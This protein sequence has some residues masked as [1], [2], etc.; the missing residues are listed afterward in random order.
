MN[1]S[2][3][4]EAI[5]VAD[6]V[7]FHAQAD[8]KR[9]DRLKQL[10]KELPMACTDFF[11]SVAQTTSTLTRLVYAYDFR[12]FFQYLTLENPFFADVEPRFMTDQHLRMIKMRDIDGFQ[13]YLM[14]YY[15][16]D[17]ETGASKV[18]QNHELGIMRKLCSLRSLFEYLFKN[19][20]IEANIATLVTLPKLHDK[21]ILRL[22]ADE[23]QKM[24]DT[25]A[26][27]EGLSKTQQRYLKFTRT[28]D[29]A[30]LL[31]FLG[32]GIRVSEC[33]GLDIDDLDFDVNAF[34]V[35]RKGGDQS[36]LYFPDQVADAL[37]AYL[38]ERQEI[39]PLEGHE[40]ALFLSLKK[41]R[42]T[43]RAVENMVKKYA[44]VA[45]P[46][47]KRISP[48]KLRSTFGT[49]LY[50][51][52]GDIYLVADVLGHSD[53]NTTRRHYA[54]MSDANKRKASRVV[55]LP[56]TDIASPE[57]DE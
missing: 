41:R 45:A 24:L 14:Q 19:G 22:E 3:D 6:P 31:L 33:V 36:I 30:M 23:M 52:T 51:E 5:S 47:K 37:K 38:A 34:L 20:H 13:E 57:D 21:P 26:S 35:T 12:L 39:E 42:M 25:V 40:N 10:E 56:R 50:Q 8:I 1:H 18:V 9:L 16:T 29:T 4:C 27:G 44:L 43:Q 46:L 17:E 15:V 54:A 28:R 32:T 53:V 11:R 49:N 7:R 2:F 48:H 55:P